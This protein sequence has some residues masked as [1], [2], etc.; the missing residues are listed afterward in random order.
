MHFHAS[1]QPQY[2]VAVS[3]G[4][5]T[6]RQDAADRARSYAHTWKRGL[7]GRTIKSDGH[8]GFYGDRPGNP[9]VAWRVWDCSSRSCSLVATTA[10][11]IAK[12]TGSVSAT[13]T[14]ER[15]PFDVVA[16]AS[17][18]ATTDELATFDVERYRH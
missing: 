9:T 5:F 6:T 4:T 7:E 18:D 11:G 8:D 1:H 2:G 15:S 10:H 13:V 14:V 16:V 3:I 12:A 17:Y